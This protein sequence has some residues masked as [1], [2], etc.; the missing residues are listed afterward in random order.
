MGHVVIACYK[1]KAGCQGALRD[2]MRTHVERLRA[3]DLAT[4]REPILMQATDGTYI[5]VFEWCSEHAM[6][7]AHSNLAVQAMWSEYAEVCDYVPLSTIS[8]ATQLFSGFA[9]VNF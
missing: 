4:D 9:P 8:E 5:E 7:R 2:L 3:E 1:P 6:Q